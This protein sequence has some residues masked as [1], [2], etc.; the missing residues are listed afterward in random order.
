M[1]IEWRSLS[2]ADVRAR[3]VPAFSAGG[4][5]RFYFG[6][7]NRYLVDLRSEGATEVIDRA[8]DIQANRTVWPPPKGEERRPSVRRIQWDAGVRRTGAP[9]RVTAEDLDRLQAALAASGA[10][11][12]DVPLKIER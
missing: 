8:F 11:H 6:P 10:G 1:S 4:L 2:A 7:D 12:V 9:L 3:G 5:Q